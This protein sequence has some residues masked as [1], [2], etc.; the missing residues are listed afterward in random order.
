[1]NDTL[2]MLQEDY[3][4]D[5]IVEL[6]LD[7]DGERMPEKNDKIALIDADTVAYTACLATEVQNEVLPREYY[8]DEEW[9][10]IEPKLTD[11]GFYYETDPKEALEKA[12]EKIRKILDKT[13]CQKFELHFSVGRSNFRYKLAKQYGNDY[14]ANRTARTPE[15]LLR[16][17]EDLIEYAKAES[18]GGFKHTDWEADDAVVFKKVKE[19]NKYILCAL[20]KDVLNSVEGKH[21]NYYESSKHNIDMKWVETSRHTAITWPFIQ[22]LTGDKS[23]NVIGLYRVGPK[24][25]EKLLAGCFTK[26]D[27]WEAVCNA[28]ENA[29]RDKDEALMNYNLVCMHLLHQDS[30]NSELYIKLKTH[31]DLLGG[32]E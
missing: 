24:K 26:K 15:G 7:A 12:K 27:L 14:K 10:E 17:K 21:F 20:D 28:Y 32:A 19:P 30:P 1:M 13:G 4:L 11:E 16:L 31:E 23:D 25:A 22:T 6:D 2:D 8:S 18:A 9:A 3:N 5:E 29:N